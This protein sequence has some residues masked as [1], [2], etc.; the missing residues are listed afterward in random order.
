MRAAFKQYMQEVRDG[1]FPAAEHTFT[2][3]DDVL[4][5]LY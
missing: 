5:K 2:V 3:A 4:K 1:V